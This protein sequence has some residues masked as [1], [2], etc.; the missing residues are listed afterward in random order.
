MSKPILIT[1]ATGK[2]GGAVLRALLNH[3][4]YKPNAYPIYALTRNT[5]S[6]SAKSL[7]SKSPT[8]KLIPGDLND[9]PAI[10]ASLPSK[11]WGVF[12]IQL[13]GKQEIAQGKGLIDA[14]MAAGTKHFVYTGVDRGGDASIDSPTKVPHFKSKHEIEHHLI[15]V[16]T[17]S[18]GRMSYTI[19]R[20]AFF[21]DNLEWGF[22]GKVLS[23]AWRDYVPATKPLQVID[24]RDIGT[25]G[26]AAFLESEKPM[27]HNHALSLA[28]DGLTFREANEIFERETGMPIPVTYGWL[29][30]V[31]LFLVKDVRLMFDWFSESGFNVDVGKLRGMKMGLRDFKTWVGGSKFG[32]KTA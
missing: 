15:R 6:G 17:E 16:S 18:K 32:K 26:A 11:P 9:L 13:P 20:P 14:A 22:I 2:Q 29:A 21:L 24:T 27:Y 31:M 8:I 28:G 5:S 7:A 19:L 12:S 30:S 1:G 4:S 10:F 23:T 25:F 3:P